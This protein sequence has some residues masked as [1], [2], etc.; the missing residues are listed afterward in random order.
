MIVG[1][2]EF[3]R[4][5]ARSPAA[6]SKW[7]RKG[8]PSTPSGGIDFEVGRDW[9]LKNVAGYVGIGLPNT[10]VVPT[11]GG[12]GSGNANAPSNETPT[13]TEAMRQR[14]VVE[15]ERARVKLS[16]ERSV[17]IPTDQCQALIVGALA[18]FCAERRALPRQL[19][20]DL[21]G[22]NAAE[23]AAILERELAYHQDELSRRLKLSNVDCGH[24]ALAWVAFYE[25]WQKDHTPADNSAGVQ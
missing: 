3:G 21:V 25:Q 19:C 17:L 2:R 4:L 18:W 15:T 8:L 5:M 16:K 6:V 13:Y 12:D 23:I 24:L 11:S 20:D 1:K 10:V 22:R 9:V 14:T 7:L